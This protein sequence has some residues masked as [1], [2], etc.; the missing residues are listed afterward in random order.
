MKHARVTVSWKHGMHLRNAA[1]VVTRAK[2]FRSSIF[3]KVNERVTD[4]RSIFGV[5][6]LCATLGS[7]VDLEVSGDD[8]DAA[9]ATI[10]SVFETADQDIPS[11]GP[12]I[13]GSWTA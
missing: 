10:T 12:G 4:A 13:H 2:S 9:L 6:L 8:E 3:L 11:D 7:V 5:L 1:R